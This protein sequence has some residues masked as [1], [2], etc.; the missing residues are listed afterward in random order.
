M[1]SI[2]HGLYITLILGLLSGC[3]PAAA[4]FS[5]GGDS[6]SQMESSSPTEIP[7]YTPSPKPVETRVQILMSTTADWTELHLVSGTTWSKSQLI[8]TSIEGN[9][10]IEEGHISLDQP[11][12]RAKAGGDVNMMVEITLSH[13]GSNNPIVL[14][15][16]RGDLGETEVE[17]SISNGEKWVLIKHAKSSQITGGLND[18]MVEIP[19]DQ[20]FGELEIA[21]TQIIKVTDID[22]VN[23]VIGLPKGT[24]DFAWW[25]DTVFYEIYVRSFFDSDGDGIGDLNGIIQKLDYLNDGDPETTS[26]LGISGIWLMP[27]FPSPTEHGYNVTDYK[28]VNPQYGTLDH[29]K[30]LI[31]SAHQRGIRVILDFV[32]GQ[33]SNQHPWFK[34]SLNPD[35]NYRDWYI[36]VSEDPGYA[37]SWGQPVWFEEN[38]SYFYSTYSTYSPDLNLT[39][40]EV[41][42]EIREAVLFWL[43]EVG[44]DGF[45][46]DSAKHAIEEGEIQANSDSTHQFWKDFRPFYKAINPESLTVG[47]VWEETSINSDYLQGDEFDLSFEFSLAGEIING[48]NNEDAALINEQV[49]LSYTSIPAH[50]FA[51]F[52]TNHDQDR[53]MDQL[54]FSPEKNKVAAS[55]LL[56][57]PGVPFMYYGEEL[58][59]QGFGHDN[60]RNPMQWS[61]DP[62]AG[63]TT[64]TP[65]HEL[66]FDW[67]FNNL[68]NQIDDP[69]SL[70][71]HYRNLVR[72]RNQHAALRVGDLG[73][74]ISS[75]PAI[76]SILRVS[77]EEAILVLVNL[78]G[79][80]VSDYWLDLDVSSL[81]EGTYIPA[82]I[83]G[84][85][86]FSPLETND[87][88]GFSEY[89]P[90][91]SL[92]PYSTYILQLQ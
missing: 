54:N 91:P 15:I 46:L 48:V 16:R 43:E 68:T 32:V 1:K 23:P 17:I 12:D 3:T 79:D 57:A 62:N 59:L 63:F 52:L 84:E 60:V 21:E 2:F 73:I 41:N 64:G 70:F 66:G 33:T 8:S 13:Q 36:W 42:A 22:P 92:P 24:D 77:Q 28:G 5:L 18:F 50:Q 72:I 45:R 69:G 58:G 34:N 55:L 83:Y 26:D 20:I 38:G 90:L 88:G 75:D 10:Y 61:G 27:I 19:A 25:N 76:Y 40:P 47:E 67:E 9:S 74:V 44:V 87:P 11:L 82:A 51:S 31:D 56:T 35:S 39:N 86:V 37:G 7:H 29:L 49:I 89:A 78:S 65:W 53:L 6:D 4:N 85:G 81:V 30:N 80:P 14:V 71:S